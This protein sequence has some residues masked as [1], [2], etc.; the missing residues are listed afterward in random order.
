VESSRVKK[1]TFLS[2]CCGPRI[3]WLVV[4]WCGPE[5]SLAGVEEV[6]C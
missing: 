4:A 5:D 1:L 6:R 3:P 2:G